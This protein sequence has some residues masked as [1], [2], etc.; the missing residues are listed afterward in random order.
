MIL[1]FEDF[2]KPDERDTVQRHFAGLCPEYD[3]KRGKRPDCSRLLPFL[4][5]AEQ[6]AERQFS[7]REAEGT[8]LRPPYTTVFHLTRAI[9]AAAGQ[10]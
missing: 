1:H 2:D 9:K 6:R 3:P 10:G 7:R 8:P 4:A 5:D